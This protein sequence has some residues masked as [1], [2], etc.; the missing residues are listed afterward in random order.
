MDGRKERKK[1]GKTNGW[2]DARKGKVL[3][4]QCG[5]WVYSYRMEGGK[6]SDLTLRAKKRSFSLSWL[7]SVGG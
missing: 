5:E 2:T 4:K 6:G 7:Y 3:D 1:E